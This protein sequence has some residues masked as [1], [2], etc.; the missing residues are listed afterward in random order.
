MCSDRA[1]WVQNLRIMTGYCGSKQ[2]ATGSNVKI[3]MNIYL[4]IIMSTYLEVGSPVVI[5][6]FRVFPFFIDDFRHIHFV[7]ADVESYSPCHQ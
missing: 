5:S 7:V 3:I 4:K 6:V 2:G 1:P